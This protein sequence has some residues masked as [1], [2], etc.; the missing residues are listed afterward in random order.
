ML[1]HFQLESMCFYPCLV[2]YDGTLDGIVGRTRVEVKQRGRGNNSGVAGGRLTEGP[3]RA[4][5]DGRERRLA[6]L[7][8]R[9]MEERDMLDVVT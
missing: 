7:E 4:T 5:L 6:R 9:T 8:P 2:M 3:A 1:Y